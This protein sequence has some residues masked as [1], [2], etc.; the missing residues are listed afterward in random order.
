MSNENSTKRYRI[1]VGNTGVPDEVINNHKD[2]RA[3]ITDYQKVTKRPRQPLYKNPKVFLALVLI[4][5]LAWL[6]SSL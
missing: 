4:A 1:K 5:L 6:L 3:L 2:F